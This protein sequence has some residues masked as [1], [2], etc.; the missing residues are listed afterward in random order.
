MISQ[1][2]KSSKNKLFRSAYNIL[3]PINCREILQY[4]DEVDYNC[5][6]TINNIHLQKIPESYRSDMEYNLDI[7]DIVDDLPK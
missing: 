4:L 3:I 2:I 1:P 7:I 6:R 5:D